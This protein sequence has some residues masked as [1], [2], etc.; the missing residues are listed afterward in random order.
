MSKPRFAASAVL[1]VLM[2]PVPPMKRIFIGD[3]L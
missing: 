3:Y 2:I 1:A